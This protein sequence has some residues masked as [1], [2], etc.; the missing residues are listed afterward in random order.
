[1]GA[2]HAQ[3]ND[4]LARDGRP[5]CQPPDFDS[6]G[7]LDAMVART[8]IPAQYRLQPMLIFLLDA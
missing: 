5:S 7:N 3:Q 4:A 8:V 1:M 2:L 6:R